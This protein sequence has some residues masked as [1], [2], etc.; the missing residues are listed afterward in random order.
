[1]IFLL[2]ALLTAE[3]IIYKGS[4]MTITTFNPVIT[5][6]ESLY[7]NGL[8]IPI[9]ITYQDGKTEDKYFF[10]NNTCNNCTR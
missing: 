10:N 8:Y 3:E 9:K 5:I 1:M 4:K 2:S 6:D 7:S